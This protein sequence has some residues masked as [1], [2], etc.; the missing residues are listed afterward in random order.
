[1]DC[2]LCCDGTL[3]GSVV[4]AAEERE[5]LGRIGL[6][7][8]DRDGALQMSQGCSALRGCLCSVYADRPGA[9][10]R[11]ECEQRKSVI[12]G[13]T[14]E[15]QARGNVARMRTLL[16]TIREAFDLPATTSV[17]EAILAL[18]ASVSYEQATAAA[19]KKYDT[20]I[21]AVTELLTLGRTAFEPAFAGGGGR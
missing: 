3:F 14:S 9:C 18:E 2:G 7:I 6:R 5:K 15:G 19:R 13:T 17:W 16:A 10:V 11:Y 1:M 21:D 20:G 12:A 8:V 4:V